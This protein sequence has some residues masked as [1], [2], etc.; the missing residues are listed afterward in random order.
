VQHL[1]LE[2][3][4]HVAQ[5]PETLAVTQVL[6]EVLQQIPPEFG[7]PKILSNQSRIPLTETENCQVTH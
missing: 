3:A 1:E 4:R 6:G 5:I 7:L 2:R